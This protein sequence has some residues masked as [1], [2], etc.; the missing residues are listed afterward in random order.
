M[1]DKFWYRFERAKWFYRRNDSLFIGLGLVIGMH[2]LWWEVQHNK[3]FIPKDN[4]L[5][6]IG[7][8]TIPYVD[9]LEIFEKWKTKK[10]EE[11]NN[12]NKSD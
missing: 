2:I 7:P 1:F 4:R 11:N 12:K 6:H 5:K 3:A 10:F 8:F 9:E